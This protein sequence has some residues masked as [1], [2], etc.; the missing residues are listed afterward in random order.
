MDH[1]GYTEQEIVEDILNQ[2]YMREKESFRKSSPIKI[3]IY[4]GAIIQSRIVAERLFSEYDN[5]FKRKYAEES[6]LT[7][8]NSISRE[9]FFVYEL[10]NPNNLLPE[11]FEGKRLV[12]LISFLPKRPDIEVD[13][14]IDLEFLLAI[15]GIQD[16]SF[17]HNPHQ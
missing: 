3:L 10:L 15:G 1:P 17:T 2:I 8:P 7:K 13:Y 6:R 4:N 9:K 5:F 11:T 12:V 14:S 16:S